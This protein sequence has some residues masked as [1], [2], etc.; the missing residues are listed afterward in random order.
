MV[1]LRIVLDLL[2]DRL[3]ETE[4]GVDRWLTAGQIGDAHIVGSMH[5]VM[6]ICYV[7]SFRF[8]KARANLR[9]AEPIVLEGGS[10]HPICW[11]HLI[12]GTLSMFEGEYGQA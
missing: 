11:M 1:N 2:T 10:E 7:E 6:T 9:I 4:R 8:S 3:D 12:R 5:S